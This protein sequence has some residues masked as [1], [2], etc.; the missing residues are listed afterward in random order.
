MHKLHLLNSDEAGRL[1]QF[2]LVTTTA[3]KKAL[4][5][6]ISMKNHGIYC[7]VE[8]GAAYFSH[9][10]TIHMDEVYGIAMPIAQVDGATTYGAVYLTK[11]STLLRRR[12]TVSDIS[13]D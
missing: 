10:Y 7:L 4:G 9:K 8:T 6:F 2:G 3:P 13:R 5:E 11:N 1:L 12:L